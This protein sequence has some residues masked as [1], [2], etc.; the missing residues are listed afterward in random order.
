MKRRTLGRIVFSKIKQ[1]LARPATSSQVIP[2]CEEDTT[3]SRR[4]DQGD[5]RAQ[6]RVLVITQPKAGTYMIAEVLRQVGFHHTFLHLG[7]ERLQA[8]DPDELEEG[9]FNPRKFDVV[10]G[11]EESRKLI[12][13][14]ELAVSH[15]AYAT[16]L[17]QKL[18]GFKIVHVKREL[19]S[20]LRSLARMLWHSGRG[21]PEVTQAIR[22]NGI[23]GFIRFRGR[24][25][26]DKALSINEWSDCTNVLSLKME[27]IL[28]DPCLSIDA[29]LKHVDHRPQIPALEIWQRV[30]EAET[31]TKSPKYPNLEWTER[32]EKVFIDIG[33]VEAN[34]VLGYE[35][36]GHKYGK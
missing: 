24:H 1:S 26:I 4:Q 35:E 28:A 31:L 5:G 33:G 34:Q 32:A 22:H 29:I 23:A 9:L 19:R 21:R 30:N 14:G 2:F 7:A 25:T 20:A 12:R 36:R 8:Y 10:C 27:N 13:V 11:I 18:R 6:S 17:E 16:T 15:L 3:S